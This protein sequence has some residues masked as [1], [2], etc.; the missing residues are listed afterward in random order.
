MDGPRDVVRLGVTAAERS[1]GTLAQAVLEQARQA[2]LDDGMVVLDDLIPVD[3]ADSLRERMHADLPALEQRYKA[4]R[5]EYPGHW[6]QTPPTEPEHLHREMLGNPIL[7]GLCRALFGEDI[8]TLIYTANTNM[9]GSVRQRVHCD[10]VQLQP[11]LTPVPRSPYAVVCN[12]GLIDTSPANAVELW[13][14]THVDARTYT[15]EARHRDIPE[16]WLEE[17]RAVRPPIQVAQRRG[18]VLV[19]DVRLW[20]AGVANTS[21]QVRVMVAVGYAPSW[22]AGFALPVVQAVA[23]TLDTIGV[24][25]RMAGDGAALA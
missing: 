8:R 20:H 24:P 21:G 10:L 17:R 14:G 13:P 1:A 3:L 7:L 18:S 19:R 4:G 22:Y 25:A 16:E 2:M 12:F 9:P 5:H 11:E 6:Q 23:E 15:R